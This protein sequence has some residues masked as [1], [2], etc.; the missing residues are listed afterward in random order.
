LWRSHGD[1]VPS[2]IVGSIKV[3]QI[4]AVGILRPREYCFMTIFRGR[5]ARSILLLAGAMVLVIAGLWL[6]GSLVPR[7]RFE[8]NLRV[9]RDSMPVAEVKPRKMR[10]TLVQQG[11][12]FEGIR[13]SV[14]VPEEWIDRVHPGLRAFI[15]F[16]ELPEKTLSGVVADVAPLPDPIGWRKHRYS[17][18]VKIENGFPGLRP[19][20]QATVKL[21]LDGLDEVLTVPIQ[22]LVQLDGRNRVAYREA[23]GEFTWCDVTPGVAADGF[24]EIVEGSSELQGGRRVALD[25]QALIREQARR[26]SPV[27]R[28]NPVPTIRPGSVPGAIPRKYQAVMTPV[29]RR[30]PHAPAQGDR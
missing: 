23:D 22:A 2:D 7:S 4:V 30:S 12:R 9:A 17:V 19:E 8:A 20:M 10:R 27:S 15:T 3:D 21:V 13:L 11:Y 25:P 1:K 24:V 18:G 16:D 14:G 6:H 5:K 28:D 29:P 26:G